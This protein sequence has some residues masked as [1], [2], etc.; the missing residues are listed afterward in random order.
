MNAEVDKIFYLW[1]C[2]EEKRNV[3]LVYKGFPTHS[4][5]KTRV[6][7]DANFPSSLVLWPRLECSGII[8]AHCNLHLP[9]SSQSPASASLVAGTTGM[10]DHTQECSDTIL[11]HCNLH[12]PGSSYSPASVSQVADTTG[13]RHHAW[14]IVVFSVEIAF[15]HAHQSGS[16]SQLAETWSPLS[17]R[18][19]CTGIIIAHCSLY[20]PGSGNPPTSASRVA[21]TTD[22]C[23]HVQ[24]IF[25]FFVETGSQHVLQAGLKQ[26]TNLSLPKWWDYRQ[27]LAVLPRLECSGTISA[28][29]S[30]DLLGSSNSAT[31]ASKIAGTTETGF[32]YVAQAG[33]QLLSS[34]NPPNLALSK[35]WD[36]GMKSLR[37]ADKSC[38]VTRLE[39][40]SM[41]LAHCNLRLLGSSDSPAPAS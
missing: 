1:D 16:M 4:S 31:S 13:A 3:Y 8:S 32:F 15:H 6:D 27:S 30:L 9:G 35:C 20:L 26:S 22:A 40:S 7:S 17:P 24:L 28:H 10:H 36:T 29:C 19:E 41:I 33:L 14:L 37:L 18:L 12:L 23:H 21:E 25:V 11:A 5:S 39:Y 34:S 38:S 2:E